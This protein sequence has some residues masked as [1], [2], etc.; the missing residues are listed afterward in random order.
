MPPESEVNRDIF[1]KGEES[2]ICVAI[3]DQGLW[4]DRQ[5]VMDSIMRAS[6]SVGK[7]NRTYLALP[8]AAA[9]L[10]DA[11]L[12]QERGIGVFT[13]DQRT[14]EEALPARH[15]E[16]ATFSQPESDG[17]TL[18]RFESELRDLRIQFDMLEEAVKQLREELSSVRRASASEQIVRSIASSNSLQQAGVADNLPAFFAGNPWLE[19]LSRRGRDETTFAG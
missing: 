9:S 8:K 6:I 4:A 11:K 15:F 17:S 19:V 14:V 16:I 2:T 1:F 5:A 18:G 13:Y 3:L 10:I 12:F 7:A